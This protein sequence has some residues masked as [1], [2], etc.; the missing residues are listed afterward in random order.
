ME[1]TLRVVIAQVNL[2]VGDV[3]D[4][5]NKVVQSAMRA[6]DQMHADVIVFPELTLVGY[7]PEDLLLRPAMIQQTNNGIEKIKK[8]IR[9]IDVIF[10]YP[11]MDQGS[12]Y[13]AVSLIRDGEIVA[14]Y[15]KQILP[16]YSVF[17]E[18]RYF[19]P[20]KEPCVI[21]IKGVPIGITI[22][23]DIWHHAPIDQV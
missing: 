4:N 5:A 14:T 20:G 1:T 8:Q 6:R 22:C 12:L 3:N 23:E 11:C 19:Q 13:N 9:D 18:K 7:P 15:Y 2:L 16:N 17:D 10:G 21:N